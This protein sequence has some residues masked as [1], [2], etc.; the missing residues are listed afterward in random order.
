MKL[1]VVEDEKDLNRIIVRNLEAE[2]YVVDSC[3]N[4][5]DALAYITREFDTFF[6]T[7]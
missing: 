2:G 1:L 5:M 6:L 7:T 4:G 3:Y